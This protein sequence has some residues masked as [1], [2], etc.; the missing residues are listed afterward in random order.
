MYA[1]ILLDEMDEDHEDIRDDLK[2]IV[3]QADRCKK[4]VSGLL[5][6]ARQNKTVR[7]ETNVAEMV[8]EALRS[9]Q[10]PEGVEVVT[11]FEMDN[12]V[13]MIDRDQIIQVLVNLISNAYAAMDGRG[14]LTARASDKPDAI[15]LQISDTG[16]GIPEE[17][18]KKIFEPFYTTKQLGQGTGLGLSVSYGIVKMHSGDISV[19][20]NTD[21]EKGPTGT[22]FTVALPRGNDLEKGNE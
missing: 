14:T 13:A 19:A 22:T 16:C 10:S 11:E 6:F 9:V 1:H 8:E 7:L 2:L 21:P 5:Q 3:D 15:V 4:I 12:P 20:S 18:M 17:T